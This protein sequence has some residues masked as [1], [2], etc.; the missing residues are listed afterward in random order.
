MEPGFFVEALR[1]LF[2]IPADKVTIWHFLIATIFASAVVL[3]YVLRL[4]WLRR[5]QEFC[6][7]ATRE[8]LD[9]YRSSP[10]LQDHITREMKPPGPGAPLA[11]LALLSVFGLSG[12]QTDAIAYRINWENYDASS[13]TD[14]KPACPPDCVPPSSC[15]RGRC[16][17]NASQG[18]PKTPQKRDERRTELPRRPLSMQPDVM[19]NA[20]EPLWLQYLPES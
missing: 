18:T 11:V 19:V 20:R 7:T 3:P 9:V 8:Q 2:A 1:V 14:A 4:L 17:G 13:A 6:A 5:H 16:V 10:D 15:V 12:T